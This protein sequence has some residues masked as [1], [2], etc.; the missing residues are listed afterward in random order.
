MN[1]FVC[2]EEIPFIR[3]LQHCYYERI[4]RIINKELPSLIMNCVE[5]TEEIKLKASHSILSIR[6]VIDSL[7]GDAHSSI[8]NEFYQKTEILSGI[9]MNNV[10]SI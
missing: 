10:F 5:G 9:E 3:D 4:M 2:V 6:K 8:L 1:V 7:T